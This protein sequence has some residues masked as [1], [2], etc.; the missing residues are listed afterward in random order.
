MLYGA[1]FAAFGVASP[2]LP[3][4]LAQD[5]LSPGALGVVLASG[6]AI[7][8]LAGPLGGRVADSTGKPAM[9][10][11]GFTA[12]AAVIATGYAAVGG[13]PLLLLVSVAH[14]SVLAPITPVADA[15]TLGSAHAEP[16]F[17]YGWVRAAGSAAFIV[18][19]LASGQIVGRA[20]LGSIIWMNAGLLAVAA[21]F[22]VA[23]PNRVAGSEAQAGSDGKP[24]FKALLHIPVFV[25]LM[26]AAMLIGGSHA[27]HDGF[28]VI[29]WRTAGLSPAR[30]SILWALSVAAEVA[31]FS[32]LGRRM[33]AILG[34][35]RA[36]GLSAVAGIVRWGAAA[37]TASFPVLAFVEPLHGLT[38]ALLHLACMD[39]I[40]R[41]V[42]AALAATAQAFYATVAMGA[43]SACVT[44]VAGPLY[45]RFGAAAFWPMAAI[46][47]LALPFALSVRL[48]AATEI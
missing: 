12:A 47:L 19:T 40:G 21:F 3:G 26:A 43:A 6:T 16:R 38:F 27:M 31:V 9:V 29:R 37:S 22:A 34:P 42:P 5:G 8:L 20:G 35:G 7:R 2:F 41:V 33:L 18:G 28:E 1:V 44:L 25:K 48:P 23:V 15:L 11:A 46:C 39:V 4:L 13:L 45:G 32:T 10:L 14:A 36:V 17:E 30:C 24:S